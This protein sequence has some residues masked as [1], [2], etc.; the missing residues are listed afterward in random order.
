MGRVRGVEV[1][2]YLD[3]ALGSGETARRY[4]EA[5]R[6]AGVPVRGRNIQLQGRDSAGAALPRGRRARAGKV[7]FNLLCLNPEQM[8]PYLASSDAP[9]LRK[10]VNVGAWSWEVDVVPSGWTEAARHVT[11]VW[12]CSAFTA[13]LITAATGARAIGVLPPLDSASLVPP[14]VPRSSSGFRVLVM[15]DYLSTIQRKNPVGA[16]EAYRAAFAPADGAQLIVKSV[17]G[18]HRLDAREE[19]ERAASGRADITFRDGTVTARERDALV[20]GC[21]C[22]ISLHRSEGFGLQLAE[23]MSQGKPVI[24]T[25]YGGNTEF[26]TASNSYLINHQMTLV[27][28]GCEHY[29]EHA[30][31][32]EPDLQQATAALRA[33]ADSPQEA[34]ARGARALREV[35]AMLDPERIGLQMRDRLLAL[36]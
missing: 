5:L 25:A 29:P 20:S 17:N 4:L 32:A 36:S 12:A 8:V 28:P 15:F 13:G 22:L 33:V 19:V 7:G 31:W 9:P 26:M 1:A 2:G 23:A 35:R 18:I 10:R 27:G 30:S 6:V 3:A 16:I 34:S 14:A 24:A 11:E 21:D